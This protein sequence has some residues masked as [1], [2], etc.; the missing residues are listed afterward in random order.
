[1]EFVIKKQKKSVFYVK[2]I[3]SVIAFYFYFFSI[4]IHIYIY[5][6]VCIYI[7][8]L[9]I[10]Y[11]INFK[12]KYYFRSYQETLILTINV[13]Q[14]AISQNNICI[15]TISNILHTIEWGYLELFCYFL[16]SLTLLQ[17]INH[18]ILRIHDTVP[19]LFW[20]EKHVIFDHPCF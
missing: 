8:Y 3:W 13:N 14:S 10:V 18:L 4:Y 6:Y 19:S 2:F 9:Y 17:P 5:I 1:M 20:L 7:I 16:W 11:W 12:K 15:Y